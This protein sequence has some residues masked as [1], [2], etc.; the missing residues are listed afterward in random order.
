MTD[1]PPLPARPSAKRSGYTTVLYVVLGLVG[2]FVLTTI[3]GVVVFV[4]SDTGK[5]II[6]TVGRSVTVFQQASSA[7]GTEQ[8]RAHGCTRALVIPFDKLA[9]IMRE[10]APDAARD[11]NRR[12]LPGEG[13][14]VLCQVTTSETPAPACA[15]VARVYAEAVPASPARFGVT[16]QLRNKAVCDGKYTRDGT[17]VEPLDSR[18]S[19]GDARG[20]PVEAPDTP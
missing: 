9:D 13:T 15:D 7:P 6:D 11:I 4:R 3:V 17:Y 18:P 10:M 19:R 5:R 8:L 14:M 12:Q 1:I 2:F 20:G 16:V